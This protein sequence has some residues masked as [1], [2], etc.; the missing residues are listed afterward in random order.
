MSL[1]L[2]LLIVA[3][4]VL[5]GNLLLM[6]LPGALLLVLASGLVK[7]L[8]WGRRLQWYGCC[9]AAGA[10]CRAWGCWRIVITDA[11][12]PTDTGMKKAYLVGYVK[13]PTHNK[14]GS[15]KEL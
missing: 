5:G 12:A 13:G 1:S 15:A 4:V 3:A 14:M 7:P 10:C 2:V 6:G 8:G 9:G 11:P